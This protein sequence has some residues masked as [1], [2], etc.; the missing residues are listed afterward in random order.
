MN[1]DDD[2][3]AISG[4]KDYSPRNLLQHPQT[5]QLQAIVKFAENCQRRQVLERS[6]RREMGRT[7]DGGLGAVEIPHPG[8]PRDLE[9]DLFAAASD[10]EQGDGS[11]HPDEHGGQDAGKAMDFY[12]PN[13][14]GGDGSD[15]GHGEWSR[16]DD[17]D[18]RR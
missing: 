1:V 10:Q 8:V 12:H 14:N 9:V 7:S 13:S 4:D 15:V 2:M 5:Q 3:N 16:G 17:S 18:P 6:L 11:D